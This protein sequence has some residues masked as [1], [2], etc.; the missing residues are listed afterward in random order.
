MGDKNLS[1]EEFERD[2]GLKEENWFYSGMTDIWFSFLTSTII[3]SAPI[4]RALDVGCGAGGKAPYLK[5]IAKS[6]FGVDLSIDAL[7]LSKNV[8]SLK[9]A[10]ATIENLPYR[11]GSFGLINVFDVLEHVDDD[12]AAL[13]ELNRVLADNGLLV[14]A[15]PAFNI[16]WSQHDIANF[17]KRRYGARDL[18]EKLDRMGF[19]VERSSYAGIVLF[20]PLL[21]YR[22]IQYRIFRP[23]FK[24]TRTRVENIPGFLNA[25]LKGILGL[26]SRVMKIAD[27]P[28]G[29][30]LLC[31][32]RK[33]SAPKGLSKYLND[34]L[35]C[36]K[37]GV[38][39]KA[40]RAA[41]PVTGE[42][43][44]EKCLNKY[45]VVS[46]I[47]RFIGQGISPEKEK[48]ARNFG[49]SWKAFPKYFDF[50]REQFQDW[51]WP[52]DPHELAGKVVLDAGC[53]SG[54][55]IYQSAHLGAKEVV[56]FDLSKA[57][58]VAYVNTRELGNVHLLQADIY[59]LPLSPVFD[60]IYCIGV[61]HHLPDPEEGFK[62]LVKLLKKGG[63][64]SVWVY[65]K[66]G[67]SFVIKF[68]D[69][70]RLHVTSKMP[71]PLLYVSAY[72]LAVM[73]FLV[74]KF[75]VRPLNIFSL[76][77]RMAHLIPLN[78]YLY[79]I[80]RFNF[81]SIFNIVFDQ[82]VAVKT[83]YVSKG[84]IEK[85]FASSGLGDIV[86]SERNRNGWRG[87]AVKIA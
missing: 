3:P 25:I 63:R 87:T 38:P 53:G 72:P 48:T 12:G 42:L 34:I 22:I 39:F 17:H 70:I 20:L 74:S 8:D 71:L 61:L 41:E 83:H 24:V 47:P 19:E 49:Y 37:C 80:S 14:V 32:A 69:P 15:V 18:K 66:E 23:F 76:T 86:I 4:D 81:Y 60:Y 79:S 64:I 44:C 16:L 36:P 40:V 84:E 65:A 33:R 1:K 57:I 11:D 56:G 31:V 46:G 67:N 26:E 77:R 29:I 82:L 6:V 13:G 7:R 85:W 35:V 50:Y 55:H 54:R 62:R 45:P 30:A 52:V 9:L 51:I 5:K 27:F 21:A 75:I 43:C 78:D 2:F 68:I 58:D 10:Q 73:L 28:C 59:N